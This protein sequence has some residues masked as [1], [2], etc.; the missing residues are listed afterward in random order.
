MR[1]SKGFRSFMQYLVFVGVAT[2]FWIIL[3]LNDNVTR[4]VD[5]RLIIA[6]VPDSVTFISDPPTQFHVIVRDKGTNLLRS[7]ILSHPHIEF[8]FRDFAEDGAFRIRKNEFNAALK[9]AFGASAQISS[10][11]IDSIS[12]SYTTDKG[13]RV[14]VVVRADVAAAPGYVISEKPKPVQRW[15]L[16]YSCSNVIDTIT[17]VY[18]EPVVKRNVSETEEVEVKFRPIK[19]VK[20][21]PSTVKVRIPV[22]PLVKKEAM[23]NIGMENVPEGQSLLLFPNRVKVVYYVPM[24]V[25]SSDLAPME[26]A[27]DWMD[28]KRVKGA[29]LPIRIRQYYEYL[30]NPQLLLDSVEYSIMKN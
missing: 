30:E 24:S 3:S 27:V 11:S 29:K 20:I 22:E 15:A 8:N 18:T 9:G 1:A 4:S 16:I 23:L 28:T 5:L 2:L 17:R 7:G 25:F 13:K 19:G 21:F 10:T 14:P 12:L 26:V 6:N